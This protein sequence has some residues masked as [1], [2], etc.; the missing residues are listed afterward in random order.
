MSPKEPGGSSD[1]TPEQ[2]KRLTVEELAAYVQKVVSEHAEKA[3]EAL[4]KLYERTNQEVPRPSSLQVPIEV[5]FFDI[6]P[7]MGLLMASPDGR[8]LLVTGLVLDGKINSDQYERYMT[9]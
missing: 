9:L 1:T 2:R 7:E 5:Y 6:S 4:R 8:R 3:V